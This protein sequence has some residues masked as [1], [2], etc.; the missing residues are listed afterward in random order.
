MPESDPRPSS[1]RPNPLAWAFE[2]ARIKFTLIVLGSIALCA[3]LGFSVLVGSL[4]LWPTSTPV[5]AMSTQALAATSISSTPA[6][7]IHPSLTPL[8]GQKAYFPTQTALVLTL[9]IQAGY[10]PTLLP[11]TPTNPRPTYTPGPEPEPT[12]VKVTLAAVTPGSACNP[13]YPTLC[14]THRVTCQKIGIPNFPVL[15]PDPFG[16]DKDNDGKG[17]DS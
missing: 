14:L 8:P 6:P 5:A 7:V 1:V 16:Y 11:P 13:A 12:R 17:C 9:T 10:S 2:P 15:P 4:I 3:C